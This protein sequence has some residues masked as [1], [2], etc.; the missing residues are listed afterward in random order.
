MR[1]RRFF[2]LLRA[3]LRRAVI[4][5]P[6]VLL[7]AALLLGAAGLLGWAEASG[8]EGDAAR[9]RLEIGLVGDFENDAWLRMGLNA[10]ETMDSSRYS[11][12]FSRRGSEREALRALRAGELDAFAVI[13]EGFL[14]ALEKGVETEPI[15]YVSG[16]GAQGLGTLLADEIVR[17]VARLLAGTENAIYA[18]QD[19][20]A[21]GVPGADPYA[22]GDALAEE[23]L[24]L[25]LSREKLFTVELAGLSGG[26]GFAEYYLC[27]LSLLALLFW[28]VACVP[29]FAGRDRE[30]GRMLRASGLGA[31]AQTAAEYLAYMALMLGFYLLYA[32]LLG[33]FGALRPEAA[34]ALGLD[35]GAL[36]RLPL[37][38][39]LPAFALGAAQ[40]ALF[41]LGPGRLGALLLQFLAAAGMAYLSGCFYPASF[42]PSPL[43]EIGA[44]LPSGAA[45]SWM[46]GPGPLPLLGL[47]LYCAAAL[48][49]RTWLRAR[50]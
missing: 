28:G 40:L 4:L 8:R 15:R 5:L 41:G 24:S 38:G 43:R 26:L 18:A 13:P 21:S 16:A 9:R 19:Y 23:Y 25:I 11:L 42:F 12:R 37:R 3:E 33:L 14:A 29:I 7:A 47:A 30:L 10:L 17:A 32:A 1:A 49:L 50:D 2:A 35:R 46:G 34:A 48:A 22:A 20:I 36:A 6:P 44:A 27:A 45:L 31:F 39:L